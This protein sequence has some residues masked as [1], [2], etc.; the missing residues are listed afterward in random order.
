MIT[1]QHINSA[2]DHGLE[3]M[4]SIFQDNYNYTFFDFLIEYIEKGTL[5]LSDLQVSLDAIKNNHQTIDK[6][7]YSNPIKIKIGQK[8]Y[9]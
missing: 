4:E 1:F 2:I 7:Y 9:R 3:L 8:A 6:S 5:L